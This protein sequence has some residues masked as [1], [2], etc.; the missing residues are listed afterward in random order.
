MA[1][2]EGSRSSRD[3]LMSGDLTELVKECYNTWK[4]AKE[5]LERL[6][7]IAVRKRLDEYRA[8]DPYLSTW[9]DDAFEPLWS[10]EDKE[11]I[12]FR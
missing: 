11:Y 10:L 8:V 4:R 5:L 7:E 3:N 6:E 12:E 2:S 1:R 9:Y